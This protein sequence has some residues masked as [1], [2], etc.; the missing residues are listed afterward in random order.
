MFPEV[1]VEDVAV[2]NPNDNLK[3]L[4]NCNKKSQLFT[5]LNCRS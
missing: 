2:L 3:S 5:L 1:K 4:E